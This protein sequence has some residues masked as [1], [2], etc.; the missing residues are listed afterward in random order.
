MNIPSRQIGLSYHPGTS[1]FLEHAYGISF[2]RSTEGL[3]LFCDRKGK[4]FWGGWGS[5]YTV[6]VD[7]DPKTLAAEAEVIGRQYGLIEGC[8]S[9]PQDLFNARHVH[10]MLKIPEDATEE[11]R[12]RLYSK[13]TR[14]QTNRAREAPLSLTLEKGRVPQ[15]WYKVYL[16]TMERLGSEVKGEDYFHTL[17]DC[18][19][20]SL[21]FVL[22]R[23][24]SALVASTAYVRHE[25]YIHLLSNVSQQS[26]LSMRVNN[27]AYDEMIRQAIADMVRFVDF[28]LTGARAASLLDFKEGFGGTP[29]FIVT[30]TFGTPAR[31][32]FEF[33]H[34]I[35]RA[36]SRR[37]VKN[38]SDH[39]RS[40]IS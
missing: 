2:V 8:F 35:G 5:F 21:H 19:G 36:I 11:S 28:G 17:A 34:R 14:N 16:E 27:L 23:D 22:V 39:D 10:V 4:H 37:F 6:C 30:R 31:R 33:A 24:G 40:Q 1:A 9:I 12:M 32:A 20:D 38:H 18:F 13:T 3:P 25:D 26:Y 29:H 7:E 15:G